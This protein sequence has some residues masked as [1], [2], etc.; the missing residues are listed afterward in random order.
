MENY[1]LLTDLSP[2]GTGTGT[3]LSESEVHE[4]YAGR[5]ANISS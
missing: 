2:F 3:Y 4:W 1:L 5:P